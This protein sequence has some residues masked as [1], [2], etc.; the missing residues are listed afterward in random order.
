[1]MQLKVKFFK[2]LIAIAI[3]IDIVLLALVPYMEGFTAISTFDTKGRILF[4]K[5]EKVPR[6]KITDFLVYENRIYIFYEDAGIVNIYTVEGE[7]VQGIQVCTIDNSHGN[8]AMNNG[9]LLIESK[10]GDIYVIDTSELCLLNIV[11]MTPG[12]FENK[13]EVYWQYEKLSSFFSQEQNRTYNSKK[14]ILSDSR[15]DIL[16]SET[17]GLFRS[18]GFLPKRSSWYE[19]LGILLVVLILGFNRIP[20]K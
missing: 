10:N 4:H 17:G 5:N 11:D 18:M 14:Y 9:L 2:Y 13:T 20:Y 19:A 7:F 8:M 6:E 16:A 3:L 15:E 12:D 1:M